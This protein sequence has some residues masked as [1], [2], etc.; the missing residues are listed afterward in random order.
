MARAPLAA[1]GILWFAWAA[2]AP[3]ARNPGSGAGPRS[4]WSPPAAGTPRAA[5]TVASD[6]VLARVGARRRVLVSDF[7]EA[8][9]RLEP[10]ARP[11]SL[12]PESARGFLDLLIG[13]EL[14]ADRALAESWVW[15]RRE[16]LERVGL[17]DRLTLHAALEARLSPVRAALDR[18]GADTSDAAAGLAARDS[19]VATLRPAFDDA[20]LDRLAADFRAVPPPVAD[21][22]VFGQLRMLAVMPSVGARDSLAVLARTTRGEYRVFELLDWLRAMSPVARPR[23]TSA[24]Q[25][26]D[27]AANALFER[28]L[29]RAAAAGRLA[30]RSEIVA[31][32]ARQ[33]EGH[34]VAH[35]V[36]REVYDGLVADSLS[37]L[38][39]Y[40]ARPGQW[41]LPLRVR[42]VRLDLDSRAEAGRMGARLR[43][44][45][46]V[47]RLTGSAG[48][49]EPGAAAER[50]GNP[51]AP[52]TTRFTYDLGAETDPALFREALAAGPGA[53]I[54]PDSTTA[55][56]T[57]ARVIVV[58]PGR[59]RTFAEARPFVTHDWLAFE[60][61]RRMQQLLAR[62]R[63]RARVSVN[64]AALAR[65]TR[66]NVAP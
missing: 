29:R 49:G 37:L 21:S 1:L 16:S 2:A 59:S 35:F 32:L 62:L 53:V 40:R 5:A 60:G 33:R 11:D 61:E 15:T 51:Q 56:W 7:R 19:F 10:P 46:E 50:I 65:L 12:T 58:I 30:E 39:F 44:T 66:K 38:A 41:A 4:A 27:L 23:V 36:Q 26:R 45:A 3:A 22:G 20:L 28:E 24:S 8:W 63:S 13:K 48:L 31:A 34:A 64:E 25:V 9:A 54:G 57:V 6:S 47:T 17:R 43:D 52:P 18:A 14:L 55:G 42:V